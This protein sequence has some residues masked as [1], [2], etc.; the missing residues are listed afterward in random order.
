MVEVWGSFY[1]LI[2]SPLP[3]AIP[4]GTRDLMGKTLLSYISPDRVILIYWLL[5]RAGLAAIHVYIFYQ[6]MWAFETPEHGVRYPIALLFG[7]ILA[8]NNKAW[9]GRLTSLHKNPT[10]QY[11]SPLFE[12]RACLTHTRR[13]YAILDLYYL[14][15]LTS[16]SRRIMT[17]WFVMVRIPVSAPCRG[18]FGQRIFCFY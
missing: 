13:G 18:I 1:R 7:D 14:S 16:R 11:L 3:N 17:R 9:T 15:D 2:P 8:R 10:P 5:A 12:T 6:N 4:K